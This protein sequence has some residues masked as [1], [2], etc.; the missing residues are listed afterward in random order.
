[1]S[2]FNFCFRNRVNVRNKEEK[3]EIIP[4]IDVKITHKKK[5][6]NRNNRN[7]EIYNSKY[8]KNVTALNLLNFNVFFVSII[9]NIISL[10]NF[11]MN[12]K[13]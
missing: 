3:L 4:T 7:K 13:K 10:F 11:I 5:S 9:L 6:Q 12:I 1:M 2:V 8:N